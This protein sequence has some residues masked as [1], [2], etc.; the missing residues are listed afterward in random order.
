[1]AGNW[2]SRLRPGIVSVWV[3]VQRRVGALERTLCAGA[4]TVMSWNYSLAVARLARFQRVQ[5]VL[6][7][8]DMQT[9]RGRMA[10]DNERR[11]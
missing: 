7:T 5:S 3:P 1:M 10:N 11:C 2:L 4:D 9:N 6:G 8:V